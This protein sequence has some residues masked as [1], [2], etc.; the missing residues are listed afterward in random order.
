[1]LTKLTR[2]FLLGIVAFAAACAEGTTP[3]GV[4]PDAA[5]QRARSVANYLKSREIVAER[6]EIVGFGEDYPIADN[7]T[8][9]GRAQNRRVELRITGQ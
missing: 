1:M 2:L 5:E 7:S 3:T 4:D 9:E 8:P 6:F